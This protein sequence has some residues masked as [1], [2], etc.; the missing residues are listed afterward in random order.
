MAGCATESKSIALGG[1]LGA[2]TGAILGGIADPGR[3]GEYRT[4]NV[5]VGSAL[6]GMAG[7]ITASVIHEN[8]EKQKQEAY[9]QGKADA[10]PVDT[11][12]PPKLIPAHWR[13]EVVET[14]RVGNRLIPRHVEYIITEPARWDD[15]N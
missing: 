3:N 1:T 13:S 10:A 8:T 9:K 15:G 7:M 12:E 5:I 11:G 6:G 2:G 4:R 14:K